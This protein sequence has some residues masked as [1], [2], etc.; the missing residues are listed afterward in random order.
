M[1]YF[2]LMRSALLAGLGLQEK[3]TEFINDL[4]KKGELSDSQGAKL[5][6]EWTEK[7]DK[8]SEEFSKGLSEM[9]SK[10]MGQ[11]SPAT[12]KDIQE[13]SDRIEA[14]AARVGRLEGVKGEMPKEG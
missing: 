5:V 12:K 1:T 8:T 6:K 3:V 10:T 9:V 14:L 4:V 13:L 7:A 2:D 11:V